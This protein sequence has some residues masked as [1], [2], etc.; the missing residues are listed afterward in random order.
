[1]TDYEQL[2]LFYLGRIVDATAGTLTGAPLLYDSAHL[3]THAVILGMTGSGKTGLGVVLIEEAALDGLPA[4]V[5]DPK[6]DL[7]NLLLQFPRMTPDDVRPW[8]DAAEAAR[9]GLAPDAMASRLAEQWRRGLEEWSQPLDRI[10]R[11]REAAEFRIYTPGSTAGRPLAMLRSLD[12]PN[13]SDDDPT[14]FRDR[15]T[16]AAASL[17]SWAGVDAD[18]VQ[19]RE[20]ILVSAILAEAWQQGRSVDLPSL[21]GSIQKPPFDR[22]GV[23]DLETFFP[24]AARLELALRLNHLLAAP[25]FAAWLEGDPLDVQRLLYSP[26][27]RPRVSVVSLAHLSE[28]ERMMVTTL[29]LG[30]VVAWMRAQPGT[31]ALRAVLYMDEVFGFFPPTASPPSKPPMLTLLK[32]ARA[33]GLGVV[34]VTQNPVDLDYKGLGNAGTWM[35]GRLQTER[36]KARVLEGLAS[37]G[38][39]VSV[40]EMDRLISSLGQRRFVMRNVHEP[41]PQVFQVRW[42]LSLLRGPLTLAQIRSLSGADEA[43]AASRPQQTPK[44]AP[45]TPAR[46]APDAAPVAAPP[47]VP[48][49]L[50][51]FLWPVAATSAP[52]AVVRPFVLARARVHFVDAK[53]GVDRWDTWAELAPIPG[54]DGVPDW[55][56]ARRLNAIPATAPLPPGLTR[57]A[58]WSGTLPARIREQWTKSFA[59]HLQQDA[60]MRLYR[61]SPLRM[62]SRP[63]ESEGDFRVRVDLAVRERRDEQMAEVRRRYADRL[64]VLEQRIAAADQRLEREQAQYRYQTTNTAIALGSALLGALLGRRGVGV[65]TVGRA[66]TAMRSAGRIGRERQDVA[67]AG[68]T[69]A[70]LREQLAALQEELRAELDRI[71][72][73]HAPGSAPIEPFEIRP[74]RSD[75]VIESVA[76]AWVPEPAQA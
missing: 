34:L 39:D 59:A 18:P 33:A 48:P 8:V 9:Q 74:R 66:A 6:G 1:M 63:D 47:L 2:G 51:E 68:E 42:T 65:G 24:A 50:P 46:S 17:L 60:S 55:S 45:P 27:G 41:A 44:P 38:G 35:I 37:A 31:S 19:S 52:P 26:E 12:P 5:I 4:L 22:I 69:A 21:I 72:A 75:L 57:V 16:A 32:Q 3:T 13:V 61:C 67:H 7:G 15:V 54:A 43:A 14:R 10:A 30:E 20:H 62:V 56:S 25:G 23:F 71:A 29:L 70:K 40:A 53:A 64:A 76:L 36:D 11:L 49:D 73:D 28:A 58:P